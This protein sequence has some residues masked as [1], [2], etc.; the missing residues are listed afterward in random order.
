MQN[1][2]KNLSVVWKMTGISQV[3][4]RAI[5]SLKVETLMVSFYPKQKMHELKKFTEDVCVRTMTNNAKFEKELTCRF[6]I[7]IRNVTNV[8]PSIKESKNI[9]L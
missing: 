4:T 1:F 2:T 5:K 8:D 9:A 3:F 7:D 6:N